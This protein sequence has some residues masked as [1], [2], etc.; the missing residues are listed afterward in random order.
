MVITTL[1]QKPSEATTSVLALGE[2]GSC[3]AVIFQAM[4]PGLAL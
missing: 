2:A 1:Q 3:T 4:E